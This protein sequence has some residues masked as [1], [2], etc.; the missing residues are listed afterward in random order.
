MKEGVTYVRVMCM[1]V[2][3]GVYG[4]GVEAGKR[5]RDQGG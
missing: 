1:S 3:M 4:C 5:P 2:R